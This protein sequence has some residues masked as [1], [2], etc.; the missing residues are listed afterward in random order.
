MPDYTC[1]CGRGFYL[2]YKDS[3][4]LIT[5][6]ERF[7]CKDC[8]TK[9]LNDQIKLKQMDYFS[10]FTPCKLSEPH[11]FWDN[12][13]QM[14]FRS[15]YESTVARYLEELKIPWGYEQWTLHFGSKEYTPDFFVMKQNNL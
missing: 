6:M 12:E 4:Q 3:K 9:Y 8:L 2:G 14:Y 15:S 10:K 13:L 1:Y 7:C 11:E 5:D